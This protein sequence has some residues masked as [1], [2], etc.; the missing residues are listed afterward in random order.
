ME[1]AFFEKNSKIDMN[2][3]CKRYGYF[4]YLLRYLEI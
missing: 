3:G 2:K 4:I 1:N